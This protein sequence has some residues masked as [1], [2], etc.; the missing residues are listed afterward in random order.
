MI[1]KHNR[2]LVIQKS[3][4]N[5]KYVL[6]V[7]SGNIDHI[8]P[9]TIPTLSADVIATDGLYDYISDINFDDIVR[10]QISN[11]YSESEKDVFQDRFEGRIMSVKSQYGNNNTAQIMAVGHAYETTR[12]NIFTNYWVTSTDAGII[13]SNWNDYLYRTKVTV[14]V[15]PTFNIS[16]SV[17]QDKKMVFDVLRDIE[18]DSGY[19]YFFNCVSTYDNNLNLAASNIE[20]RAMPTVPTQKYAVIQGSPG[21][22]SANFTITGDNLYNEILYHGA[23]GVAGGSAVDDPSVAKY[24]LRTFVGSDTSLATPETLGD[25]VLGV[26]PYTK[27]L[28]V[29][30]TATIQGTAEPQIGDYVH[31]KIGSIDI[32]T[33]SFAIDSQNGGSKAVNIWDAIVNSAS[34]DAYMHV[35]RVTDNYSPDNDSI[36]LQFGRVEKGPTDYIAEFVNNNRRI[37]N[38]FIN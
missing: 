5:T 35:I 26:L 23:S 24:N 36:T 6:P 2:H 11:T 1:Y 37:K 30:G 27:G 14:P 18:S 28:R 7:L 34:L 33:D 32:N 38:M 29:T 13:A 20:F 16:Y 22:L 21:L 31:I 3:G 15:T 9:F 12:R 8:Y 17:E 19:G 4:E 10:M 25:F